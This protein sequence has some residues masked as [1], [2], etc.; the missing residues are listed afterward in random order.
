MAWE[1]DDNALIT[2]CQ[3]CHK[4][5]HENNTIKVYLDH[6]L[7]K[8]MNYTPCHRCNGVGY[9]SE[10][11]HVNNGVCFRCNGVRYEELICNMVEDL[12]D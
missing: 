10:F 9:F 3:S 4:N 1:Y 5:I 2:V 11:A 8:E 12:Y 7:Q 6:N